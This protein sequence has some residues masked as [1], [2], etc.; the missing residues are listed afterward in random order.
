MKK[1]LNTNIFFQG[2]TKITAL[3]TSLIA[4]V[5][6]LLEIIIK[7]SIYNNYNFI[8]YNTVDIYNLQTMLG[9]PGMFI[10]SLFLIIS[11]V[12][13]CGLFKRKKWSTFLSGPFSRMDIRKRELFLM[14]C[15]IVAFIIVFLIVILRFS[16][17]NESLISYIDE[18]SKVILI[19]L[20]RII[21]ISLTLTSVLF[22]VDSLTSN[23]YITI[24]SIFVTGIYIL[25]FMVT[26]N[27]SFSWQYN[28][29]FYK[30]IEFARRSI[31]A[32]LFGELIYINSYEFIIVLGL[33]LIVTILCT[34]ISKKLTNKIK[35]EN[36]TDA[37]IFNN[38]KKIVPFIISTLI[39]MIVGMIIFE[40]LFLS[41]IIE[42]NISELTKPLISIG[43]ISITSII[44]YIVINSSLKTLKNKIPKKYI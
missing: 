22:L 4:V 16:I 2:D 39:G 35:V 28:G 21:F 44:V 43:I 38:I 20:V 19:D 23:M 8:L 3:L 30:L 17:A 18:F 42:I 29:Y 40:R 13:I 15:C 7:E 14:L 41:G 12:L 36:M 24:G 10:L 5:F 37:F 6:I 26:I 25:V 1:Y 32:L 34:L 33:L 11:F 9:F 31:Y 27:G